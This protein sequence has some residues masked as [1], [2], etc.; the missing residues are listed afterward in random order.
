MSSRGIAMYVSLR[1]GRIANPSCFEAGRQAALG[2]GV[3]GEASL[4]YFKLTVA[5]DGTAYGGWQIQANAPTVQAELERA[6]AAVTGER[7]RALASSRTDAGVHAL[8]QVV[9][10]ASHTRLEPNV[11][12]RALNA[13][14]PRDI[15]VLD[16]CEAPRGF[17]ATRDAVR[18]RYRYIIQD[19]PTRDVIARRYTWHVPVRLDVERMRAAASLL[20]GT[21]DFSSFEASGSK[22][23]TSVRTVTDIRIE[24]QPGDHLERVVLEIEA[25]GFLYNMVR[26]IVGTLVVVGRGKRPPAWVGQVLAARDRRRAGPTAPPQGLFLL[27]VHY[28][29]KRRER[30]APSGS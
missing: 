28:E 13:N 8:G 2:Q 27:H 4:R 11:L 23:A 16:A 30:M 14:L 20:V 26:N 21:Y 19:G 29:K 10:F 15:V 3:M 5:Y 25:D 6:L 12:T 24:R 1:A 18:K 7:I 9:S 22:R 17:H